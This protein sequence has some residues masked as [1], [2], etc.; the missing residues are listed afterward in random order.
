M[1]RAG[2]IA[3]GCALCLGGFAAGLLAA[4]T[5]EAQQKPPAKSAAPQPARPAPTTWASAGTTG[6]GGIVWLV[7]KDGHKLIGCIAPTGA[8][9]PTCSSIATLP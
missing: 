9:V 5:A 8:E 2:S 1:T 6:A 7:S 3:I 4:Q